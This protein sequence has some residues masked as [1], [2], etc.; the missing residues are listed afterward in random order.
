MK[1]R[2]GQEIN[3]GD[4]I[5]IVT[6]NGRSMREKVGRIIKIDQDLHYISKGWHVSKNVNPSHFCKIQSTPTTLQTEKEIDAFYADWI[7]KNKKFR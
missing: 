1:D 2:V 7:L 3:V 5:F 6:M 4:L